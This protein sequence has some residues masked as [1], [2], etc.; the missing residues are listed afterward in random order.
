MKKRV[1][2]HNGVFIPISDHSKGIICSIC[3]SD[4]TFIRIR[5]NRGVSCWYNH[6]GKK[7][8]QKCY[9]KSRNRLDKS[10]KPNDYVI[11]F[12]GKNAYLSFRLPREICEICGVTKKERK[13]D[14]HHYFYLVIMKW[15]CT[16]SV[17]HECHMR[18][19]PNRRSGK[20]HS[21]TV[22]LICS[23]K[24]TYLDKKNNYYRWYEY[25]NGF[26]CNNCYNKIKYRRNNIK[27]S[28]V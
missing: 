17:C 20:D 22:C 6:N 18:I 28:Q 14:R 15:A 8:C 2:P 3:G 16:I 19:E 26:I 13:I 21:N 4:K 27:K 12:C 9:Q 10:R 11:T 5:N 25:K 24:T 7:I 1:E 23:S